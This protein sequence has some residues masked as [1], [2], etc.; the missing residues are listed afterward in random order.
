MAAGRLEAWQTASFYH[1]VH[2]VALLAALPAMQQA[3]LQGDS[4][5]A[6][7]WRR[8]AV[9][10]LAG[11]LLFSGSLYALSLQAPSWL[12]PVTPLGGVALIAGWILIAWTRPSTRP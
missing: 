6:K 8:V 5:A 7:A 2:A 4:R 9:A 12:G 11:M 10:W 1:A 3:C